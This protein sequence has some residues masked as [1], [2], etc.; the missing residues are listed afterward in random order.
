MV[1]YF[2]SCFKEIGA[3]GEN[4]SSLALARYYKGT[5]LTGCCTNLHKSKEALLSVHFILLNAF[6]DRKERFWKI[7]HAESF[8]Y[9]G[10]LLTKQCHF[11]LDHIDW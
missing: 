6:G 4:F 8:H 3:H 5:G 9:Q 7:N 1:D 10:F 11:I 2:G